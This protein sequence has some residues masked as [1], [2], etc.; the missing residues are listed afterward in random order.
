MNEK[1][2]LIKDFEKLLNGQPEEG[3][4]ID[5]LFENLFAMPDEDFNDIAPSLLENYAQTVNNAQN[6]LALVQML[7]ANGNK[8][9]DVTE[10]FN[11]V[12]AEIAEAEGI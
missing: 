8:A 4:D 10:L 7:N 1:Q 3:F 6:K 12:S 11:Q 5:K 9:E 2:N